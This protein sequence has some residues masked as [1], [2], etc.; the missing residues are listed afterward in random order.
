MTGAEIISTTREGFI[1]DNALPY[2]WSNSLLQKYLNEAEKE[3]CRRASLLIDKTTLL[4]NDSIPLTKLS[5]VVG[6]SDYT[7]SDKIIRIKRCVGSWNLRPLTQKMEGWLDEKYPTWRDDEGDPYYF[8]Q[9]KGKITVVPKPIANDIKDVSGI[10][11]AGATAT[12]NLVDHGYSTGD[13]IEHDGA[14]QVEYNVAAVITKIDDNNYSYTVSG[15][16]ATPATGDITATGVDTITLEVVR[17]PLA[18][19]SIGYK[20]VTGITRVGAIATVNLPS[21]G[22]STGDVISHEGADQ[23]EYNVTET[24]TKIDDDNYSFP[25]L[26]APVTPATGTLTAA[27]SESPE[28]PEE[29]HFHLIDWIAHLVLSNHDN[30]AENLI[31]SREHDARF[32]QKFGKALSATTESN[33]RRKPKNRGM[34]AK[35]Y[36]F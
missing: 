12:V 24:I 21:H 14:D 28:I 18:D 25:A 1:Y 35:E 5:L 33:R 8:T 26:G 13:T 16:P 4:D 32:T 20:S 9:E 15:A 3:A 17:L 7:V 23:A 31:K 22:Y 19:L 27:T 6:Q 30:E 34:R 10:T 29:Y 2:L 36:G 11:L